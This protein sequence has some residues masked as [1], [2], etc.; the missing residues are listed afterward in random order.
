MEYL[1]FSLGAQ[2]TTLEAA[3]ER[4]Q[5]KV[6]SYVEEALALDGGAHC[7]GFS[8]TDGRTALARPLNECSKL[9][10]S[11]QGMWECA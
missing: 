10:S 11:D 9:G 7:Q 3:H 2:D 1:D 4:L 8:G 5:A 6:S